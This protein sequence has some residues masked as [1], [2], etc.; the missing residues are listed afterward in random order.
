MI[1][2]TRLFNNVIIPAATYGH[3]IFK[4][5]MS[6]EVWDNHKRQIYSIFVKKLLIDAI[7]GPDPLK[8]AE[9]QPRTR[10][11]IAIYYSNGCHHIEER[12]SRIRYAK[13]FTF[14]DL[15]WSFW[16]ILLDVFWRQCVLAAFQRVKRGAPEEAANTW[17]CRH[18]SNQ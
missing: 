10:T 14:N 3:H 2:A 18:G 13:I 16:Q 6:A 1:S 11:V 17:Q 5:V 12:L 4:D 9:R 8:L 15:T 7:F